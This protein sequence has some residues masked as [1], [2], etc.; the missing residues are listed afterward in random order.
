MTVRKEKKE[1]MSLKAKLTILFTTFIILAS[2]LTVGVFAVKNTSFNVGGDI[3]FNVKGIE[4]T[5]KM[6]SNAGFSTTDSKVIGTDVLTDIQLN[7]EMSAD[8]VASEFASWSGL[9]LAFNKESTTATIVLS[10]SNEAELGKDNYLNIT[11]TATATESNNATV[12]VANNAG[13]NWAVLGPKESATFT[14]TFSVID[15]EYSASLNDFSVNF[16][17]YKLE[18]VS[19]A[20]GYTEE[21]MTFTCDENTYTASVVATNTSITSAQI[22]A[23]VK[24]LNGVPCKVT[25]V[26]DNAFKDC[27]SLTSLTI[28]ESV[29][30]IGSY[31]FYGCRGLTGQLALPE[32]LTNIGDSAF[33]VC[34]GLTGQLVLPAGVTSIGSSAFRGC[35]GLSGKLIIPDSVTN[36]GDNAFR[37]CSKIAEIV[38]PNTI[39]IIKNN[40]F[41]ACTSITKIEIPDSVITIENNAFYGCTKLATLIIPESVKTI[42][43]SV[44]QNCTALTTVNYRGT[45][46]QW[47]AISIGS[48][49]NA[50]LVNANKVYN[51]AS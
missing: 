21:L 9:N 3:L 20:S 43:N 5:I 31:A 6:E 38:I 19:S 17:M 8:Q 25:T 24:S 34:S 32:W 14:I 27:A 45:E 15:D 49:N 29:S 22:P 23:F 47:N 50:P 26:G 46:E 4:A 12:T 16:D 1:I 42:G 40:T 10:I 2:I 33:Q 28:P 7:N 18:N 11:A 51:Y 30:T 35:Y 44:F 13:G 39:T 41:T 48:T 36:L 37:D